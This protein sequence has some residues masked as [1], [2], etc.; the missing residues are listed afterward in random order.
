[1]YRTGICITGWVPCEQ[2]YGY[3]YRDASARLP[4]IVPPGAIHS[5]EIPDNT[6]TPEVSQLPYK[7]FND[8]QGG[9]FFADVFL[10]CSNCAGHY[11]SKNYDTYLMGYCLIERACSRQKLERKRSGCICGILFPGE[12]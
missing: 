1:M 10:F 4:E 6:G 2:E 8:P 5:G 9:F 7:L 12:Y 3:G 11:G